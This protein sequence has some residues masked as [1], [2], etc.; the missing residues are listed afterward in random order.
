MTDGTQMPDDAEQPDDVRR[1]RDKHDAAI[2]EML[3]AL[4]QARRVEGAEQPTVSQGQ[5]A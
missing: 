4:K 3:D 1:K 5:S 2:K